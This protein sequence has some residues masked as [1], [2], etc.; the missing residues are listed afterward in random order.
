MIIIMIKAKDSRITNN[1]T[2][3]LWAYSETT[4]YTLKSSKNSRKPVIMKKER[5]SCNKGSQ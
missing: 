3:T 5:L 4:E 2:Q 1:C